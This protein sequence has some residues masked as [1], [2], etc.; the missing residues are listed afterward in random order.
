MSLH[1]PAAPSIVHVVHVIHVVI[2][3]VVMGDPVV[4]VDSL[5]VHDAT[6]RALTPPSYR[7]LLRE[8]VVHAEPVVHVTVPE[9]YGLLRR[10]ELNLVA[11]LHRED[12]DDLHHVEG[13]ATEDEP[14]VLRVDLAGGMGDFVVFELVV[15]CFLISLVQ[16]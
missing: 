2:V 5:H 3:V 11:P 8:E 9:R 12:V 14:V 16:T 6:S 13:R 15:E 1:V 4:H 7:G 10:E